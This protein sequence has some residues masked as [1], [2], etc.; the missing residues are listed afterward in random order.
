M[1]PPDFPKIINSNVFVIKS[2]YIL[3]GIIEIFAISHTEESFLNGL[4]IENNWHKEENSS[5]L[6]EVMIDREVISY[7]DDKWARSKYHQ[8]VSS[9]LVFSKTPP[10]KNIVILLTFDGKI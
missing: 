6:T 2:F 5:G 1:Q 10:I 9:T 7:K 3:L 8:F 4:M